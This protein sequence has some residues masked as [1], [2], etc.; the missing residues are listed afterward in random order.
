LIL[1]L[2]FA[3]FITFEHYL[4]QSEISGLLL[5]ILYCVAQILFFILIVADIYLYIREK[6]KKRKQKKQ[7]VQDARRS[8]AIIEPVTQTR[9]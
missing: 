5:T 8:V 9:G 7:K 6:I 4:G 2:I 1:E 3:I